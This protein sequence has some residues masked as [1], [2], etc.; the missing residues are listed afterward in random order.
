MSR[1]AKK[2]GKLFRKINELNQ[3]KGAEA[4]SARA[5]LKRM[6]DSYYST[7]K[8][9]SAGAAWNPDGKRHVR[10]SEGKARNILRGQT[11]RNNQGKGI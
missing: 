6:K 7:D 1:V 4:V 2:A 8:A 11:A 10:G 5:E 9:P 3:M